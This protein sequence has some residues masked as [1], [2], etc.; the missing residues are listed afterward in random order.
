MGMTELI[1]VIHR[2]KVN[3]QYYCD[4]LLSMQ[5]LPAIKHVASD[6]SSTRQRSISSC[7]DTIKQLQQERP[8][9]TGPNLWP[10]NSPNQNLV[11]Y[12]VWGCYAAERL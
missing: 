11:D 3:D 5:T 8:D 4:V 10:S 7:K 12:K 1:F 2:M 6:T 9:F